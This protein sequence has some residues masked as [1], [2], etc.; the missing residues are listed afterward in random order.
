MATSDQAQLVGPRDKT[1][2]R[3]A[4]L[5][6]HGEEIQREL[7]TAHRGYNGIRQQGQEVSLSYE[8]VTGTGD[9]AAIERENKRLL[10]QLELAE[11][12]IKSVWDA[13]EDW[14]THAHTALVVAFGGSHNPH[15]REFADVVRDYNYPDH[16]L[17]YIE[18]A[19]WGLR[20]GLSLLRSIR[21]SLE[22]YPEPAPTRTPTFRKNSAAAPSPAASAAADP[23][24]G[25][26][27][28]ISRHPI[29]TISVA[30]AA[31][32][33][34]IIAIAGFVLRP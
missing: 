8:V 14:R 15:A 28:G 4:T 1:D 34:A 10:E 32:A 26:L 30:I 22:L 9:Q 29:L 21:Q 31:I 23:S 6:T 25:L 11:T 16:S 12:A 3:L 27:D 20:G 7:A 17:G 24:A 18:H 13:Y 5:I 33:S 2:A 19:E